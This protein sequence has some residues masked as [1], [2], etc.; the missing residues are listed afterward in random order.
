MV[1]TI[2]PFATGLPVGPGLPLVLSSSTSTFPSPATWDITFALSPNGVSPFAEFHVPNGF[3]FQ[4]VFPYTHQSGMTQTAIAQQNYEDGQSIHLQARLLDSASTQI[5][6]ND[7]TQTQT[8]DLKTGIPQQILFLAQTGGGLTSDQAAQLAAA[9]TSAA[10]ALAAVQSTITVGGTAVATTVGAILGGTFLDSLA[11]TDLSG[12]VTC[13]PVNVTLVGAPY[14]VIIEATTVPDFYPFTA[15]GDTWT[16]LDL[17]VVQF[18]RG[19][20]VLKRFGMHTRKHMEYPLPGVILPILAI[21]E[22]PLLPPDYH[23]EV[24]WGNGV[25][26]QVFGMKLP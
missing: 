16:P 7:T 24:W 21:S 14:G 25:C 2:N 17:A 11:V 18:V 9:A 22:I 26:G 5:D 19:T 3:N 12:G 20:D 13:D 8:L 23:L 6:I 4:Q 15:P 10:D 1:V